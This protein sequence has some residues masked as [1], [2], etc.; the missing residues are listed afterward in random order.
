MLLVLMAACGTRPA[1]QTSSVTP[2]E[3]LIP[4]CHAE[5]LSDLVLLDGTSV[6][7][8]VGALGP[9]IGRIDGV[10]G[11]DEALIRAWEQD[12]GDGT[13]VQVVLG[14][15]DPELADQWQTSARLFY[16][17]AWGGMRQCNISQPGHSIHSPRPT[18]TCLMVTGGTIIDAL[19]GEFIVG[20]FG[21]PRSP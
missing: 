6:P 14:S 2:C 13:T 7:D 21:S 15:A 11:F 3:Q 10:I 18:P 5:R 17:I 12:G 20:G 16:G 4:D 1:M 8:G 19:T 9:V